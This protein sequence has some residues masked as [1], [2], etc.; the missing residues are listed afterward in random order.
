[1][2]APFVSAWFVRASAFVIE[3]PWLRRFLKADV[4]GLLSALAHCGG[5]G[6]FGFGRNCV[7]FQ[8]SRSRSLFGAYIIPT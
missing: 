7:A 4:F 8:G 5:S 1:M 3:G 2:G 6:E